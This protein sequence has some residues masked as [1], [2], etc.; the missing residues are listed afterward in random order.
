MT[1]EEMRRERRR[2]MDRQG[3]KR[4]L[5][6]Q[7]NGQPTSLIDAAPIRTHTRALVDLGW[8]L[9][10][11]MAAS[12]CAGTSA[13]LR[14]I[15]NGTS[16]KAERKF[17]AVAAMPL[18]V[19]VPAHV[20][21]TCLVPSLGATR[22]VRALMALGW[23]HEDITPLIGRTSHHLASGRYPRMLA[24]DWRLVDAAY[25]RLSGAPGGSDRARARAVAAGF[26]PPLA[27]SDIDD[28]N[29]TPKGMISRGGRNPAEVDPVIVERLLDGQRIPSTRAEKEEAMRQWLADGKSA[30]SLCRM[31]GWREARYEAR[32]EVA[33]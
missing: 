1:I 2:Y 4:R 15:A 28:P 26:A 16:A 20:P 7:L 31:H 32:E 6:A 33:S 27:W 10:A 3:R 30:V 24:L 13:G 9:E 17:G 14:L 21:D 22:R 18:S 29:E 8:S 5:L 12:G 25:E 11:I 23:R 19:H